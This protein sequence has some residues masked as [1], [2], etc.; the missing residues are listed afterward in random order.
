MEPAPLE[1]T[2]ADFDRIAVLEAGHPETAHPYD[3]FLLSQIPP[4]CER[5]LEVGCGAGRLSRAAARRAASVTAIDASAEMIRLARR[6]SAGGPNIEFVCDDFM[7]CPLRA[8]AFDCILTVATLHHMNP[9]AALARM[10]ALLSPGG[11]L[12][13]HDLRSPRGLM[14]WLWSGLAAVARGDAWSWIRSR[15]H[16]SAELRSAWLDHGAGESYPTMPEVHGL[17]RREL[18]GARVHRHP[19]WRYTVVWTRP[20]AD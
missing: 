4:S 15:L 17:C 20:L 6:R 14:D 16:E 3:A 13:I 10:K 9:E 2:R 19:L 5:L 7:T 8:G 18:P 12:V 1:K 11:I